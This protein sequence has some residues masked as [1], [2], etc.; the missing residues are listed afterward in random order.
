MG[1][2]VVCGG[3]GAYRLRGRLPPSAER[4]SRWAAGKVPEESLTE[5][6][7]A[8]FPF[9][10]V[11]M[12]VLACTIL[13][14]VGGWQRAAKAYGSPEIRVQGA[15]FRFRSGAFGLVNY[16]SVLMLEAGLQGISFG[17]L[18]P[19]RVGHRRFS[20]P[21]HDIAF[22]RRKRWFVSMIELSFARAPGVVVAIPLRLAEKLAEAGGVSS[23]IPPAA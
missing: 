14:R 2:V 3:P 22:A 7:W 21:W 8:G 19:F 16:N 17:V 1:A 11:G 20:V 23:R 18:L 5:W 9:F 13:S 10:F 4:P 15:R 6:L 12:W